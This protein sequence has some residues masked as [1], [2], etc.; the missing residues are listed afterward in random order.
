MKAKVESLRNQISSGQIKT[1][2]ARVIKY[3]LDNQIATINTMRKELSMAHQTLTSRVSDLMDLGLLVE[4][5][6]T[7]EQN[8]NGKNVKYTLYKIE[9]NR[10]Q[11]ELRR[12]ARKQEK[13]DSIIKRLNDEFKDLFDNDYSINDDTNTFQYI[14]N[15]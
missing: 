1:N 7:T 8:K 11:Q 5:G 13:Y 4:D 15:E 9:S 10:Q 3:L 2:N 12:Q 6:T 14:L